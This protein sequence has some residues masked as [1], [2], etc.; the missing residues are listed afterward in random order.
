MSVEDVGG[1]DGAARCLRLLVVEDDPSIQRVVAI[2][3][4]E[5]G[6]CEVVLCGDGES[7][8][9]RLGE[10]RPHAVLLDLMLPGI[11]GM[12]VLATMRSDP[13]WLEIPVILVT[14]RALPDE[15]A[16]YSSLGVAGVIL[17]PFDPLAL[18]A[19]VRRLLDGDG[20]G[21]KWSS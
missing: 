11:D 6:G 15:V 16:H 10:V 12:Q 19:D 17:K 1:A 3:L 7:A 21:S 5:L 8:L 14:A 9:A 2:A 20:R 18:A 13:A 4:E